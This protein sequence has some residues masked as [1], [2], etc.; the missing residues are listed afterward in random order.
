MQF[1]EKGNITIQE[2]EP[3]VHTISCDEKPSIQAIATTSE[4]LRPSEESGCV[5]RDYECKRLG[6]L[7]EVL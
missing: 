6:T 5:Y 1:D 3:M 2:G 7:S 4:D